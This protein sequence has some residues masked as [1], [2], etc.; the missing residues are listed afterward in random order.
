MG[1]SDPLGC[2]IRSAVDYVILVRLIDISLRI[3]TDF[4]I[5]NN[6][7]DKELI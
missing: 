5:L 3:D 1:D 6:S 4:T 2:V 7:K